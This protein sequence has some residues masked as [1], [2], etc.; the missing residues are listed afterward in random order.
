GRT[1]WVVPG[2]S[3]AERMA[4]GGSLFVGRT[5]DGGETWQTFREGLPQENAFDIVYR[6]GL[7]AS[8][9]RLCF[10]TTTGN[11]Y[12][13]DDRGESWRCLGN[14]FPPVHSVRFG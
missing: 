9:D 13:S 12:Y 4:I 7:D 3:D 1:A 2:H 14:N 11:V 10:G 5:T 8:G 6:H